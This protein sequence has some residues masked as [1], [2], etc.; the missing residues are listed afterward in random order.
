MANVLEYILSLE[1]RVSG[2]LTKIGIANDKQLAVWAKVQRKV[3]DADNTMANCGT[4]IGSLRERI[5]ALKAEKEWIPANDINAIRRTN[6]EIKSLN[7]KI[8]RLNKVGNGGINSWFGKL[9]SAAPQL[10]VLANPLMLVGKAVEGVG[11]YMKAA[12]EAWD[13]QL[14]SEAGLTAAMRLHTGA[15]DEEIASIKRLISTQQS[16]G[17]ISDQ[18]QMSGAQQLAT[19]VQNTGSIEALVPAMNNLLVQQKGL[20]A[21][22]SDAANIG[23]LMG[24]AMK[25]NTSAL[26]DMGIKFTAAQEQ[27][28]KY[29]DEAQRAAALA[30]AITDNVGEANQALAATPEGGLQKHA[31]TMDDLQERI[32]K[33]Q[34][35]IKGM[36]LPVF[37]I[38]SGALEGVVSWFEQNQETIMTVINTISQAI[39]SAFSVISIVIDGASRFFGWW[40]DKLKEGNTIITIVSVLLGALAMSMAIFTI[41]AKAMVMWTKMVSGAKMAWAAIQNGLNLSLLAC[42]LTWIIAMGIALIGVIT[43]LCYK[44]EGWGSLWDGVVGFMKY[45]FMAY[46]DFVKLYFNALVNWIMIGVDKIKLKWYEFKEALGLGDSS[47]NQA[48]IKQITADMEERQKAI[49]DGADKVKENLLKAKESLSGI[50]MS[51]NSEKSLSDVTNGLKEKLGMGGASSAP[52][53][54][55]TVLTDDPTQNTTGLLPGSGNGKNNDSALLPGTGRGNN[56][57]GTGVGTSSAIST[58]GSRSS[59]VTINLKSL[60][61]TLSFGSYEGDRD[62]MQRDL[63]SRLIR[64]LEMA[65]SAM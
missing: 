53:T 7:D 20:N 65:N 39:R 54:D 60:V 58:G 36:L 51:W 57:V 1:D 5:E 49:S 56:S 24:E 23:N 15:S 43:Y 46:V 22:E 2:K 3:V 38:I 4:T 31:N 40:N 13:K 41:K 45:A 48:A 37:N 25:G 62:T 55:D 12:Q 9:K 29:G 14:Q 44:I 35:S 16:L 26:A 27:M 30:Q 59:S 63:E 18:V 28:L 52:G 50:D 19:F 42:P 21:T 11:N 10:A 64:V 8:N 32:G 61:E 6:K 33:L 34:K 47:E 17:V